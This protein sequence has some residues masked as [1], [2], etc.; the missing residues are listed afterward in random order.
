[1]TKYT[2]IA[3]DI[4]TQIVKGVLQANEQLPFEKDLC[5]KYDASKMTVKKALDILVS[6]GLIV[7]R[8]G[9][10][11]FVKSISNIDMNRL[12]VANQFRGLTAL[13]SDHKVTSDLITFDV[14]ASNEEVTQKLNLESEEFVYNLLRVRYVDE[15]P[16]VI[17][18]TF[19]PINLIPG[20]KK[21]H[22]KSSIYSYIEE[23]LG[24]KVQSS[25]RTIRVRKSSE[26]EQKY[27]NLKADD[28]V[29]VVEQVAYLENGT[30]FEYS[31]SVHRYDRFA[32]E[33]VIVR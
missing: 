2:Q 8:R 20:L 24:L 21:Q 11:T 27:L 18:H 6:E 30:A 9:S 12:L 13:Y 32:F 14:V 22:T 5:I 26:L 3:N 15:E 1:M 29:A 25:H 10:G 7:K 28:P 19:M 16:Y 33:T 4:R 31:I 17:E 23:D